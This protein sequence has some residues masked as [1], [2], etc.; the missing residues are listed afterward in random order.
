MGEDV[1]LILD[2]NKILTD[3]EVE[4]LSQIREV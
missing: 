4:Q 1:K 3:D 2:C